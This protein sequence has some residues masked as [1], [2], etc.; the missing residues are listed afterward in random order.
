[1]N[2][3]KVWL[4]TIRVAALPALKT[5]GKWIVK[6]VKI[7]LR[8]I[9][10]LLIMA[11]LLVFF[12]TPFL[13]TKI[14]ICLAHWIWYPSLAFI[15]IA[16]TVFFLK[17]DKPEN[18]PPIYDTLGKWG[19]V[20]IGM[21]FISVFV[22][23]YYEID[24]IWHW[25]IFVATAALVPLFW[26]SLLYTDWKYNQRSKDEKQV[27]SLNL[28]KNILLCWF[29]DLLYISIVEGWLAA[30]I[31]FGVLALIIVGFNLVNA[32]LNGQK[33]L[34][35]FIV[36]ELVGG[37]A[38]STYLISIIPNDD[39]QN[40]ILTI[41]AALLGGIFTLVGVAWTIKKGDEDRKADLQRMEDDRR[42]ETRRKYTPFVMLADA[43]LSDHFVEVAYTNNLDFGTVKNTD[44]VQDDTYYV[45]KLNPFVIKNVSDSNL[46]LKGL[47]INDFY[48]KFT[49]DALIEQKSTCRIQIG[50]N[51]WFALPEKVTSVQLLVHDILLNEYTINCMF[52]EE[53]DQSPCRDVAPDGKEYTVKSFSY[54]VKSIDLPRY[55]EK[56]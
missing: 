27:A 45:V 48:H 23:H 42:E 20:S 28:A 9:F 43:T 1:M 46:I 10:G 29:Y 51:H 25:V 6:L 39:I 18:E 32:F 35:F 38:V 2:K 17:V 34:R 50:I 16:F 41:A 19:L 52:L 54:S 56:E 3:V 36:V 22:F 47:F 21:T 7:L 5:V 44:K 14:P 37:L 55:R 31:V 26:F 15:V 30:T 12:V 8:S 33:V 4:S 40:I 24:A 13:N 11:A 53:M 49:F